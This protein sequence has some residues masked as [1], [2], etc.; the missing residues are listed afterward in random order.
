MPFWPEVDAAIASATG[1]PFAARE[2]APLGGGCINTAWRLEGHQ[3][4]YFV[5]LN[6]AGL[7]PAFA[8]EAAA[9]EALAATR[10]VRV[11]RPV[12]HGQLAEQ[13]FLVLEYL[14]LGRGDARAEARLGHDLAA[15]HAC[16][17]SRFGWERD[18]T[19]GSTPQP[20][21]WRADWVEF[22]REQRLGHQ[23]R[24]AAGHGLRWRGADTLLERVDRLLAGH[25]PAPSLLHGD[26]WGGNWAALPGGTPVVFDP[27]L[28]YGDRE[29]DLAM[30]ELF[31][32]FGR[33]FHAAYREAAPLADGYPLRRELYNLY[34]V[35]NHAN[36]FGGAYA[37]QAQ[38]LID[39]LLAA[40]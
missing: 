39:R 8:A 17:A 37:G 32:G 10:T 5:K 35:L 4:R 22:W 15:L 34:H 18:N 20:N 36:L 33:A 28:Y 11:P 27:A 40:L 38:R 30:T 26:L 14:E 13:A 25:R 2:R 24:L 31:G 7:A 21:G 9:L 23:L 16:H 29:A 19:I 3:E 6:Q 12:C 1:E